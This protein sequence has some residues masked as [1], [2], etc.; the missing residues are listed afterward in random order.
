[1]L[2]LSGDQTSHSDYRIYDILKK[3]ELVTLTYWVDEDT[4]EN[5]QA[6]YDTMLTAYDKTKEEYFQQ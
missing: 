2:I 3:L 1:V 6:L 5:I 4:S